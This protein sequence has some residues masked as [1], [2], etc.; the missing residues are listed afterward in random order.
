[1]TKKNNKKSKEKGPNWNHYYHWKTNHKLDLN[2]IASHKNFDKI[3]KKTNL[4][5]KSKKNQIEIPYIY[6]LR[7]KS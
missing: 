1:M 5:I 3:A 6:K 7:I 4:E 2:Q